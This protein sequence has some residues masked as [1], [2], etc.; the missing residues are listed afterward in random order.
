MI[1]Y[2]AEFFLIIFMFCNIFHPYRV[3]GNS[4]EPNLD[5]EKIVYAQYV[6][7]DKIQTGDIVV[8]HSPV[9]GVKLVKRVI[10]LSGQTIE[11]KNGEVFLN[12]ELLEEAYLSDIEMFTVAGSNLTNEAPLTLGEKE[13]FVMGDNRPN[14]LDSR[15]FGAITC[16]GKIEKVF[17]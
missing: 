1:V 5:D 14:S 10:A 17:F 4:M 13:F 11:I 9:D 6:D 16:H 12:N 15:N 7:C 2:I 8:F 3:E